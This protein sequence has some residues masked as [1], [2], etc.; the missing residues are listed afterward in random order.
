[1]NARFQ[2]SN[3]QSYLYR[4]RDNLIN[5]EKEIIIKYYES[6]SP[7]T[8][9]TVKSIGK[10]LINRED[11][12]GKSIKCSDQSGNIFEVR[13][14]SRR[15]RHRFAGY[16]TKFF[17]FYK[18][19]SSVSFELKKIH[20][21][22]KKT[23]NKKT[24]SNATV[25]PLLTT[26]MPI[27]GDFKTAA[28][29]DGYTQ[30]ASE[31]FQKYEPEFAAHDHKGNFSNTDHC[32]YKIVEKEKQ[33]LLIPKDAPWNNEGN[34]L[35]GYLEF[36]SEEY[37]IEKINYILHLYQIDLKGPLTPE[38]IYRMNIGVGNLEKQDLDAFTLKVNQIQNVDQL[39][40]A[41]LR[42][43]FSVHEL[44]GIQR[45]LG[46]NESPDSDLRQW[47]T[48]YQDLD[49]H[50]QQDTALAALSFSDK[51]KTKQYTGREILYPIMS[52]Y[53]IADKK[54]FKPWVDQQELLQVFGDLKNCHKNGKENW[55]LYCELLSHIVCKKHLARKHPGEA[56]RV[57][58]LIPA[59]SDP[60]GRDRYYVVSS[61]VSNSK[62]IHSYTL[63][64]LNGGD[65][66][67]AIK[68]FRSTAHSKYA[69]DNNATVR[70][71][72]NPF[73]PPGYEGAKLSKKYEEDFF[74]TRT[75]PLWV[76]YHLQASRVED[77]KAKAKLLSQTLDAFARDQLRPY[78]MN[79]LGEVMA[80]R[81]AELVEIAQDFMKKS[82]FNFFSV[83]RL[84]KIIFKY[85]K[86]DDVSTQKSDA[87]F[88][89]SL[90]DQTN[91]K[92][93][94]LV[95][96]LK[97]CALQIDKEESAA[98]QNRLFLIDEIRLQIKEGNY[99]RA[100]AFFRQFADEAKELPKYKSNQSIIVTGH[101]LGAAAAE[102]A[103]VDY[104]AND[105]RI[106][107][108]EPASEAAADLGS[109]LV[110]QK[111]QDNQISLRTFDPPAISAV[112]N[113][114]YHAY[115]AH[116]DL[117]NWLKA[118]FSII[119]RIEAGDFVSQSGEEHLGS[120]T[121]EECAKLASWTS[122]EAS[123]S[124]SLIHAKVAAIRDTPVAHATQFEKGKQH[125]SR[126][127]N[128]YVE[129]KQYLIARIKLLR[130]NHQAMIPVDQAKRAEESWTIE[131]LEGQIKLID[132]LAEERIG[133]Y[134]RT[135]VDATV[136]KK[137]DRGEKK[138][139]KAI[140]SV[141][142]ELGL[143]SNKVE[144]IRSFL[145]VT[146]RIFLSQMNL[147]KGPENNDAGH[148]DWWK[149]RDDNGVIAVSLDGVVSKIRPS[150]TA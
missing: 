65:D 77:P 85:K 113:Q 61:F 70:N 115:G 109:E 99:E 130:T 1:M 45:F 96:D 2:R 139:W 46:E 72:I 91:P 58:T 143:R 135:W 39:S 27:K 98:V 47:I 133:D 50:E 69:M 52:K 56:Y 59:P 10:L 75:I 93:Q 60:F 150:K 112:D 37:G 141:F 62:G 8:Y 86:A 38:I 127:I 15:K 12:P 51:D 104:I 6:V 34:A 16:L 30:L 33:L 83:F 149:Y 43:H 117:F 137:F 25:K 17:K 7:Q 74:K 31:A 49:K 11:L 48:E 42:A 136:L 53:T 87:L 35:K 9:E 29:A 134:Q 64:P 124:E 94:N 81:D 92:Y 13:K 114:R 44:R 146:I 68:L 80:N 26:P 40:D 32:Q 4:Y 103:F 106:P 132:K 138:S 125:S 21:A 76:G 54:Y 120:S 95:K 147:N 88:L 111:H 145:G 78:Q 67:P 28:F 102:K 100:T 71:D 55:D 126:L 101:S 142:K 129:Y 119:H 18:N 23:A 122:F 41:D 14:L 36:M 3:D 89:L 66:L 121:P 107:V 116:V 5:S 128:E 24:Q 118:K 131:Q 20:S 140:Q 73:N 123:V 110:S 97:R 148:E 22:E 82:I 108:T 90:I 63:E 144:K 79:S 57:G 19:D 105:E 84:V